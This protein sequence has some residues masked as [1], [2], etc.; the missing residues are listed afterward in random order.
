MQ[1]KISNNKYGFKGVRKVNNKWDANICINY[2]HYYLGCYETKEEAA[3]AYNI[4]AKHYHGEFANLNNVE[5]DYIPQRVT[6]DRINDYTIYC[7]LPKNRK[8][9]NCSVRKFNGG[10]KQIRVGSFKTKEEGIE[11]ARQYILG[12]IN[13]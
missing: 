11:A 8:K 2:K 4:A 9:W 7:H 5:L 13:E 6:F 10:G 12:I 3:V 1:N